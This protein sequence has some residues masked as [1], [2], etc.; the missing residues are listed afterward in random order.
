MLFFKPI[1]PHKKIATDSVSFFFPPV[2]LVN[3]FTAFTH[4]LGCSL[5]QFFFQ[6]WEKYSYSLH[7]CVGVVLKRMCD[8]CSSLLSTPPESL[9]SLWPIINVISR[10]MF[11]PQSGTSGSSHNKANALWLQLSA[12]RNTHTYTHARMHKHTHALIQALSKARCFYAL[13]RESDSLESRTWWT[14]LFHSTH[15]MPFIVWMMEER[16][17]FLSS[18]RNLPFEVNAFWLSVLLSRSVFNSIFPFIHL[19]L[20]VSFSIKPLYKAGSS[21]ICVLIVMPK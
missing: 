10:D 15:W 18:W 4:L 11:K 6:I 17:G 8:V 9:I 21:F 19:P 1:F 7:F 12:P 2:T 3:I 20:I 16:F 14:V 5:G 13:K